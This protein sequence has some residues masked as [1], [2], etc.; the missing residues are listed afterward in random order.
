[1]LIADPS[2]GFAVGAEVARP[3]LTAGRF[4]ISTVDG[5]QVLV[6]RVPIA[7]ARRFVEDRLQGLLTSAREQLGDVGA[8]CDQEADLGATTWRE[9]CGS[10]SCRSAATAWAR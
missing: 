10:S 9:A 3:A 8:R 2:H 4:G 7:D 1:M 5:V 6:E